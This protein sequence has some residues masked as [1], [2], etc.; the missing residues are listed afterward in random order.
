MTNVQSSP[1]G[2]KFYFIVHF[3]NVWLQVFSWT[4]AESSGAICVNNLSA[5]ATLCVDIQ[6]FHKTTF[7]SYL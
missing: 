4:D 6:N 1:V 5:T 7:S 3:G 2:Y